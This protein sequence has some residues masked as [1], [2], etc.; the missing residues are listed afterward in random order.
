MSD[1]ITLSCPSCGAKLEITQ[2]IDRFA[3]S[4]C[5]REHIV[6][7]SG[8]IVSLSPVVDAIKQVG[9][10]VDKTAAELAIVR[11]QKEITDLQSNKKNVL[12]SQ[13]IDFILIFCI[14]LLGLGIFLIL[15]GMCSDSQG[16]TGP[17]IMLILGILI[18]ITA[19][20]IIVPSSKNRKK[21]NEINDAEVSQLNNLIASKKS[22]I[23][24]LHDLV[25][26]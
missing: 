24:H 2:D 21:H 18:I 15:S 20:I 22:E 12:D 19:I 16:S 7:R 17:Y 25:S 10:G 8:G 11:L 5:G 13:G 6:K 9:I 26:Q 1:F 14:A 4:N 23:D 3:C